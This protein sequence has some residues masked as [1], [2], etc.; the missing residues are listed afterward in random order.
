MA[1]NTLS[2]A[3]VKALVDESHAVIFDNDGKLQSLS[4][5]F[6]GRDIFNSPQRFAITPY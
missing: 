1:D 6:S 2:I 5:D 4:Q 3:S